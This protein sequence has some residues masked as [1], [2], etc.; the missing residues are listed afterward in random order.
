VLE[1][2]EKSEK[3]SCFTFMQWHPREWGSVN[4]FRILILVLSSTAVAEVG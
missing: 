1:T 4:N 3:S 2:A